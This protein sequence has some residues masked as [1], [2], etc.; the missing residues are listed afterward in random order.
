MIKKKP[1]LLFLIAAL[2]FVVLYFFI[3]AE[4]S[5]IL[6]WHAT[7]FVISGKDL[8]LFFLTLFGITFFIYSLLDFFKIDLSKKNIWFHVLCSV[9]VSFVLFYINDLSIEIE[10]NRKSYGDYLIIPPDY[11]MYLIISIFV[12]LSLQFFFLINIFVGLIKKLKS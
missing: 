3:D 4:W 7:Y 10:E 11:N 5:F 12:L 8:T 2:L 1:Y 9:L 6:N